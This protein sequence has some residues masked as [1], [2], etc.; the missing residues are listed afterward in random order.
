MERRAAARD[1]AAEVHDALQ[2]ARGR[3]VRYA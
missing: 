2:I 3:G 1:D